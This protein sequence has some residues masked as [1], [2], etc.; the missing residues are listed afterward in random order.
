MK[1]VTL[2]EFIVFALLSPIVIFVLAY[3]T[4]KPHIRRF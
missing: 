1:E 3:F 4:A 2:K